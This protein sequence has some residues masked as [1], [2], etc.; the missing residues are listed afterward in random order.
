MF[1]HAIVVFGLLASFAAADSSRAQQ[2]TPPVQN[3]KLVYSAWT[4]SCTREADVD[5]RQVCFATKVARTE[6][7]QL[8]TAAIVVEREGETRKTLR[9][10]LPL[11]MQTAFGTRAVLDSEKPLVSPYLFCAAEGCVSDYDATPD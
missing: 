3:I 7:G 5:G 11:G 9:V 6:S 2:T 4:R 10:L 8:A 1:R